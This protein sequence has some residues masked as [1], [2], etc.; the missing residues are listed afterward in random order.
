MPCRLFRLI[1]VRHPS[2]ILPSC[3]SVSDAKGERGGGGRNRRARFPAQVRSVRAV[4]AHAAGHDGGQSW[5]Y[6]HFRDH[7]VNH[8]MQMVTQMPPAV[9][10]R[11]Q[12]NELRES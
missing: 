8:I 10:K 11:L 3:S 6:P 7:P 4:T 12:N 5:I 1:A 2:S 9:D